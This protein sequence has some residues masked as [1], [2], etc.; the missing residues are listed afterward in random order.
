MSIMENS[1]PNS[2]SFFAKTDM[3]ESVRRALTYFMLSILTRQGRNSSMNAASVIEGHPRHRAQPSR[4]LRRLGWRRLNILET[5]R[6]MLLQSETWIG[7]YVLILD[8]TLTSQQGEKTENT[9]STGNRKR[10]P[11]KGR[12][13][14]KYTHKRKTCHCF[15]HGLLLTPGGTRIP[16]VRPYYTKSHAKKKNVEHR[17]QAELAAEIINE[18]PTPKGTSVIV[19]GDTAFDAKII[20]EACDCRRFV[21]IFPCNANRVFEGARGQRPRVS[22]RIKRLS[23]EDFQPIRL[24]P[25]SGK[26]VLKRRLSAHRVG[27]KSKQRTYYVHLEE[28]EVHSVGPVTLVFSSTKPVKSKASRDS[29]KVLMTNATGLTAREIVERYGL[30]WQIELYFKE[31]KSVLGMH[32]YRYRTF[33]AVE[34]WM[35]IITITFIY[36]EWTRKRKL[37]D[38]RIAAESRSIWKNQRAFGIRQAVLTGIQIRERR[39]LAK[40]LK[41]RSGTRVLAKTFTRLLAREYRCTA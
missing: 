34:A 3:P 2:K 15:V 36:L 9:F 1:L 30:R 11:C 5:L 35:E 18:L 24:S 7:D 14:S 16:F 38:R 19:L 10:R 4:F 29:T 39:W 26:H 17:T 6:S 41:S 22:S 28:R 31:L 33:D 23:N 40:R 32:Q 8:S 27:A 21:W 37:E 13:Y 12:R 20:R 25:G